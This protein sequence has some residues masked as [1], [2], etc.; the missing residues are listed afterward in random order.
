MEYFGYA[1]SGGE[2]SISAK[3][4]W[5]VKDW[6]VPTTQKEVRSI[7]EF[8]NFSAKFILYFSYLTVSLTD[9]LRKS[10]PQ[11]K[12]TMTFAYLDAFE[13]LK[14]RLTSAPC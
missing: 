5:A 12:L 7:M 14:L 11:I 1:V 13:T 9:L 4:V 10:P 2:I 6:Q 3:N 8:C